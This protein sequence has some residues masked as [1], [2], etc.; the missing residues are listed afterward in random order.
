MS[1]GTP[2]SGLAKI[3]P[4]TDLTI[5]KELH[6]PTSLRNQLQGQ[7]EAVWCILNAIISSTQEYLIFF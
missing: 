6:I 1:T 7:E 4:S 3:T 5:S 2:G